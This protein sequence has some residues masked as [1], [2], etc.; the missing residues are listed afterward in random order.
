ML[1]LSFNLLWGLSSLM[2]AV[3]A[4]AVCVCVTRKEPALERSWNSSQ[5]PAV[6]SLGHLC[7]PTGSRS[8]GLHGRGCLPLGQ[9]W[10]EVLDSNAH[11]ACPISISWLPP[12]QSQ[13][14]LLQGMVRGSRGSALE[15]ILQHFCVL[16]IG[17]IFLDFRNV[18]YYIL[19]FR[20]YLCFSCFVLYNFPCLCICRKTRR[21]MAQGK[22]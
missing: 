4:G 7:C 15:A 14:L 19:V 20:F 21:R 3:S 1:C 10:A 16:W 13:P 12:V 9:P 17:Q 8:T 22:H 5:L 18:L 11:C 6:T 2:L